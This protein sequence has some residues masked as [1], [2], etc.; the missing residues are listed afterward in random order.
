MLPS[1]TRKA[2]AT[3]FSSVDFPEPLVPMMM[4]Q[5]QPAP[6]SPRAGAE[7]GVSGLNVFDFPPI[8]SI[9][10]PRHARSSHA[11]SCAGIVRHDEGAEATQAVIT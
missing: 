3:A 5:I 6:G 11:L 4:T 1:W 2:A 10:S 8:Q 7:L 9:D